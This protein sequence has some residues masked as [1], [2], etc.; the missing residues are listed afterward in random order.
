MENMPIIYLSYLIFIFTVVFLTSLGAPSIV[1]NAPD[2]PTMPTT[3]PTILDY[4]VFVFDNIA[5][6]FTLMFISST[7]AVLGTVLFLPFGILILWDIL[8]LIRGG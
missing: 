5:Y 2:A 1:E 4:L 8:H 7:Y 6:F 3:S